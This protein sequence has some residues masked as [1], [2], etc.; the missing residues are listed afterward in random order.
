MLYL[1]F[2]F[3]TINS[4]SKFHSG[5]SDGIYFGNLLSC[6]KYTQTKKKVDIYP[7]NSV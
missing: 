5:K 3:L 4:Q 2:L 7:I 1:S 6:K